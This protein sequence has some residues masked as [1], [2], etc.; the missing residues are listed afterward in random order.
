MLEAAARGEVSEVTAIRMH[1]SIETIKSHRRNIMG[2]MRARNMTHAVAQ[3][4]RAGILF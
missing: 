2:K 3:G 4:F 1:L